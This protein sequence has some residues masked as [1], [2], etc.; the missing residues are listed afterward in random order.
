MRV[1]KQARQ[2]LCLWSSL[3]QWYLRK[4]VSG[5]LYFLQGFLKWFCSCHINIKRY[6]QSSFIPPIHKS[7]WVNSKHSSI[8][9][10]R[11]RIYDF[12]KKKVWFWKL[13]QSYRHSS[14]PSA[15]TNLPYW[16]FSYTLWLF[17]SQLLNA[18]GDHSY[19]PVTP[20]ASLNMP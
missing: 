15:Q 7:D 13:M 2:I 9:W 6:S 12:K 10:R 8:F 14:S 17:L 3:L 16:D 5:Y 20:T 4:V 19:F 11:I 1:I 18:T